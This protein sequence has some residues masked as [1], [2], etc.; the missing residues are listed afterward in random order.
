MSGVQRE[1]SYNAIMLSAFLAMLPA[2]TVQAPLPE[3]K[4]QGRYLVDQSGK[5][6]I[7]NGTNLG[8]WLMLEMWMLA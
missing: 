4:V 1:Y 2:S 7:L 6:V 5:R 3:I 8:N